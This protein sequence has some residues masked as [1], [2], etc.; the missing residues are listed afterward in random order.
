MS[1]T[2][3]QR[4]FFR[5]AIFPVRDAI[6]TIDIERFHACFGAC[7]AESKA[8]NI[9]MPRFKTFVRTTGAVGLWDEVVFDDGLLLRHG[10]E[11]PLAE[12]T[13][14]QQEKRAIAAE[15][16]L[17]KATPVDIKRGRK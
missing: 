9:D 1:K 14:L 5:E 3:Q 4:D 17:L 13:R 12:I 7:T 8:M 16:C 10:D 11:A 2:V 6:L 15:I